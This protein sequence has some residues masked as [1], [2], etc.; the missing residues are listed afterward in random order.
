MKC[1]RK[2]PQSKASLLKIVKDDPWLKPFEAAIAGRHNYVNQKIQELTGGKTTLSDFADGH[3]YFGLHRTA[4]GWVFRE[5]APN[6]TA[7]YLIGD[8]NQ[9]AESEK[10]QL[11]PVKGSSGVWE[12]KLP[13][14]ALSHFDLYKMKVYW[15]GGE[16]ERIPAWCQ[17]VVQDE[18]TK[19]FSAQ[20]WNPENPYQFKKKNFK[21]KRDP[22]LIYECHVGM[23]QDAEKVGS[24]NEF[25]L[26]V[27]PR[28]IKEGYNCL[29][30]MAI[31]EHPYYGSFGYHVSSFFAPSSRQGTPDE[32]KQLIDEAHAAGLTVIMDL[33]QSHAVKNEIEGLGNLAGDPSQFFY[34][35][36]RREHPAWDSRS[37]D[38][39]KN[40]VIHF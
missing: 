34:K 15:K 2:K 21:P 20:V 18:E 40:E 26:N 9:W 10:Y 22:L 5:W 27:L 23:S 35:G 7:I 30:I 19:I 39:G 3:L 29:Q 28:I 33:V 38:Y 13:A 25:R 8:F 1:T 6:A 32:L 14:K 4:R 11:K 12:I 17:R 31:Q 24:Y 36:D 16:G 37:V